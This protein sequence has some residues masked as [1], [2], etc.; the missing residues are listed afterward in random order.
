MKSLYSILAVAAMG[1][2]LASCGNGMVSA[3]VDGATEKTPIT[4]AWGFRHIVWEDNINTSDGARAIVNGYLEHNIPVG[5]VIIDSPWSTAYNDFNWDTARYPDYR[6]LI[7]ELNGKGVKVI[8]WLTGAV[9]SVSSDTPVMKCDTYDYVAENNFAIN[10]NEPSHWWK[11]DG[12]HVDFTNPEAREWWFSQ[13]DKVFVDGVYGFKVDQAE[14]YFGDTVNT[15]IGKMTN[16]QFRPYYYDAMFDYVTSRSEL[17]MTI[18]RPYS[19]QGGFAAS[20][21]KLNMGWCGDFSGDWEGLKSQLDNI[22]RSA[23]RGYSAP[24]CEVAGFFREGASKEEFVRYAQFGAMTAVMINGGSNGAFTHHLPWYHGEDVETIYRWCVTFHDALIPYMFS[25]VVDSHLYGG[26]LLKETSLEQMS[27]KLGRSI[28]TKVIAEPD[29]KASFTLPAD[30]KWA[31][32]WTGEV[33]GPS[34]KIETVYALDR[35]P[36]FVKVGDI[37]PMHIGNDVTAVGDDSMQGSEVFL[38]YADGQANSSLVYHAPQGEGTQYKDIRV[39]Y[40]GAKSTVK[41]KGSEKPCVVVMRG[42]T[43]VSEVR[44]AD[45]WDFDAE[46]SELTIRVND[47]SSATLRIK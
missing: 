42:M 41:I 35:F 36:L 45:S 3:P 32:F 31:D 46:G 17:G 11:G 27:H 5:G 2:C 6:E 25:S 40:D 47:A 44:G 4:P 30:G 22:Y 34:T 9:D 1:F 13:L 16:E 20:V 7:A 15:S 33:Y 37:I 38:V 26:S 18:A 12:L 21:A 39:S 23:E 8:L 28:F 43:E 10:D 19:Y 14:M 29:G 24:G